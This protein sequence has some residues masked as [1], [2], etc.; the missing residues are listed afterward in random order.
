M[1]CVY[2][3]WIC[4][5]ITLSLFRE[6]QTSSACW[7]QSV[8]KIKMTA[9]RVDI[10]RLLPANTPQ[11]SEVQTDIKWCRCQQR[12]WCYL[13]VLNRDVIWL[14][15]I[16]MAMI[17]THAVMLIMETV[18]CRWMRQTMWCRWMR[19]TNSVMS[20]NET[21]RQCDV[22]E[23]DKLCDIDDW[24]GECDVHDWDRV[25]SMIDTETCDIC[26]L[27]STNE[28]SRCGESQDEE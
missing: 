20:M 5:L 19:Q 21:N 27:L 23:W 9:N 3:Y 4:T 24:D 22:G 13:D 1:K 16:V 18:W 28:T 11:N 15:Q 17:E 12:G 14:R 6:V 10:S 25:M 8:L 7:V 2:M 26:M